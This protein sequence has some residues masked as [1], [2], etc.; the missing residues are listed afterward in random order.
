MPVCAF[1]LKALQDVRIIMSYKRGVWSWALYDW[2]NSA[3]ATAVMSGFFPVFFQGYWGGELPATENTFYL[4]LGNSIASLII[5]ILAPVLGSIADCGSKK[6]SLLG[7]FVFIGILM[8]AL[9]GLIGEGQWVLAL[10][11]YVG[12]TLG[13]SGSVVFYDSL[14]I[15]VADKQIGRAHV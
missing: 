9:L 6:K 5:V 14:L 15:D 13:F 2:A 7:L 11:I 12:A 4:G 1:A 10:I 3:Y 8:T